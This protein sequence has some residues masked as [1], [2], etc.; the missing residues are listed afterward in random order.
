[1]TT[2]QFVGANIVTAKSRLL[3]HCLLV[4]DGKIASISPYE[5]SHATTRIDLRGACL[6]PG[7]IDIHVHGGDGADTM[8]ATPEAIYT[9]ARFLARHG[10]TSF[11]PTTITASPKAT[12]AALDNLVHLEQCADGAEF[13]GTHLEGPYLCYAQRGAQ[14]AIHLRNPD[15]KEYTAWLE[16]GIVRLITIAPELEG[17]MEL[18]QK[19]V[20]ADVRLALGHTEAS[21]SITRLAINAGVN[22]ATHIFSGMPPLHHRDLNVLSVA[23]TD[24]RVF[25]QVICDGIHIHP[26]VV[27]LLTRVKGIEKQILISDS[28]RAAGLGDGD[29]DLGGETVT[30]SNGVTRRKYDG[31]LAGSTL[32]LDQA[33][34]NVISF[35][36]IP[37]QHGLAMVTSVPARAMGLEGK[38]GCI[39]IGA[40]ADL[41]VLDEELN[42]TMT[43]VHGDVVHDVRKY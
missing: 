11:Y 40:D 3:N 12:Q 19:A 16:T 38:K 6:V 23:M 17:A 24:D 27:R 36:K 21:E 5:V 33:L 30:V 13:L 26:D 41:V 1:M 14:P 34:R 9:I 18:I 42:V 22:Q 32:T 7:F 28:I 15:P 2:T 37:L 39:Q 43:M 25:Q 10:V 35:A 20:Q 4:E 29:Y 31:G 8:D